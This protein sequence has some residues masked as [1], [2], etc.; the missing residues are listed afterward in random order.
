MTA[1][2]KVQQMVDEYFQDLYKKM[3]VL[4]TNF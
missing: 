3:E 2:K 4:M 1:H